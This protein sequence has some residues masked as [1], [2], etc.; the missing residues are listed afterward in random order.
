[1]SRPFSRPLIERGTSDP[2]VLK[3]YR[4]LSEKGYTRNSPRA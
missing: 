1:M 3:V 4:E 2:D